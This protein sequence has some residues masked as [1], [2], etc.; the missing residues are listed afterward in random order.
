MEPKKTS[1]AFFYLPT[2]VILLVVGL[3][4][5]LRSSYFVIQNVKVEGLQQIPQ[6]EIDRL[7]SSAKGQ[8]LVFMDRESLRKKVTLH[9]LVQ[10]VQFKRQFPQTL[11]VQVTER[12]PVA[13]VVVPK[14]VVKVDDHGIFLQRS[15]G[16][17][18]NSYPVINGV[19]IPDTAGPGQELKLPGLD[20]AL[21]LLRE[22]PK[23]LLPMIGEL[24]VNPIQQIT[25]YLTSGVEVRLGQAQDWKDKL[26]GL[27]QLLND[28]GYKSFEKGVRYIDF[29][30][31]KPVIGR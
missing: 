9:P 12:T 20:A 5:F 27:Y 18:N 22:A 10:S 13:L 15:E 14:G 16:W 23:E 31:A 21:L 8:N 6:V 26:E 24:Y 1:A 2:L 17:P 19:T 29:T 7:T 25:I 30:A 11:V 28:T 3:T 4:F